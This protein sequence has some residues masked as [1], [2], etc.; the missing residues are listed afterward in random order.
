VAGQRAGRPHN[1]GLTLRLG[2][3]PE[4]ALRRGRLTLPPLSGALLMLR[5]RVS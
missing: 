4:V 3:H 1:K 2:T 5:D